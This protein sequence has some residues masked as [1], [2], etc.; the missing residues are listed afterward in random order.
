[1]FYLCRPEVVRFFILLQ[2][3]TVII[4]TLFQKKPPHCRWFFNV[5]IQNFL[6][7]FQHFHFFSRD[8][9]IVCIIGL[10]PYEYS[11]RNYAR[12]L[13]SGNCRSTSL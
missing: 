11:K 4:F 12:T 5:E 6:K 3:V 10:L 1:M 13:A 2:F 8:T 9:F 7:T